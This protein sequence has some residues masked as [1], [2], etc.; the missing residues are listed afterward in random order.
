MFVETRRHRL[1]RF[2]RASNRTQRSKP[3]PTRLY[4]TRNAGAVLVACAITTSARASLPIAR[5][6]LS[7]DTTT[8]RSAPNSDRFFRAT[9][10]A[11]SFVRL[12]A[13]HLYI[14]VCLSLVHSVRFLLRFLRR[15]RRRRRFPPPSSAFPSV[16]SFVRS[17]ATSFVGSLVRSLVVSYVAGLVCPSS[18]CWP[19]R[20]SGGPAS[21]AG[22][23]L[24]RP[25]APSLAWLSCSL[26]RFG[27]FLRPGCL[28]ACRCSRFASRLPRVFPYSHS[29]ACLLLH[30][31]TSPQNIPNDP[32]SSACLPACLPAACLSSWPE[33]GKGSG[34]QELQSRQ[35]RE[36]GSALLSSQKF[37]CDIQ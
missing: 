13:H 1:L 9:L 28:A 27:P 19:S 5:P 32:H 12:L 11:V 14:C 34:R 8:A 33:G 35:R 10:P 23:S 20:P 15:R 16:R 4:Q 22:P 18:A 31:A 30:P 2:R 25:P 37:L 29:L 21:S 3:L 17:F 24:V 6:G 7:Y 26:V 36:T